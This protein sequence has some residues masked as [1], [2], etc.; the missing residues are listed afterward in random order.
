MTTLNLI[1]KKNDDIKIPHGT[2][3][4]VDN[5]FVGVLNRNGLLQFNFLNQDQKFHLSNFC[6]ENNIKFKS[7]RFEF[8]IEY[9]RDSSIKIDELPEKYFFN[10][11][12][13]NEKDD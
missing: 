2:V 6:I 12:F 5:T 13:N 1:F 4:S 9:K 3:S 10:E 7:N 8:N 11:M